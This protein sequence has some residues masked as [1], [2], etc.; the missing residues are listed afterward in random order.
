[1]IVNYTI[2]DIEVEVEV[3]D[4]EWSN[5]SIGP[6]E[7]GGATRVHQVEDHIS[8]IS[9]VRTRIIGNVENDQE[10]IKILTDLDNYDFHSDG[11]FIRKLE[12]LA[13]DF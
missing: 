8:D 3:D 5:D 13:Y 4:V 1:M 6:Y 9:I 12:N 11:D 10:N 2:N 7:Y